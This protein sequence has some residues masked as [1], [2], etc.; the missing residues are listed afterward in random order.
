MTCLAQAHR[1]HIFGMLLVRQKQAIV[2]MHF[3]VSQST[4][5]DF[6]G[7]VGKEVL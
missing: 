2:A 3:G 6:A 7:F 4:L 1:D 5:F